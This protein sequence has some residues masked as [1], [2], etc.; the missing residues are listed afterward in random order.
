MSGVLLGKLHYP[1]PIVA[2]PTAEFYRAH[3][4]LIKLIIQ[5]REMVYCLL[6]SMSLLLAGDDDEK[7][8]NPR[9]KEA[10]PTFDRCAIKQYCRFR[11]LLS[12]C[13]RYFM[14]CGYQH[15]PWDICQIDRS[16]R[17]RGRFN[18]QPSQCG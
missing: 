10:V 5:E 11:Y 1:P 15:R 6:G 12:I 17:V 13:P 16:H 9:S 14:L 18:S 7:P 3:G 8:Y 2:V 4:F